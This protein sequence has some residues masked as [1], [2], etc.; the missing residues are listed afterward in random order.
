MDVCCCNNRT[1]SSGDACCPQAAEG[2][3]KEVSSVFLYRETV[4]EEQRG[5][6]G[7][8][9]WEESFG[10][11]GFLQLPCIQVA[12]VCVFSISFLAAT[13]A[14]ILLWLD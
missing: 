8:N 4:A 1:E 14:K 6:G 9:D 11:W 3:T 5:L 10:C 2:F 12:F 7:N 13:K